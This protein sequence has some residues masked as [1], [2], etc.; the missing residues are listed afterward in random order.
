MVTHFS[1]IGL[2]GVTKVVLDFS[3]FEANEV[4]NSNLNYLLLAINVDKNDGDLVS[5]QRASWGMTKRNKTLAQLGGIV[6]ADSIVQFNEPYNHNCRV[7]SSNLFHY[8]FKIFC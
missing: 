3:S 4:W 1:T 7:F 5:N 2:Q 6:I 8:T